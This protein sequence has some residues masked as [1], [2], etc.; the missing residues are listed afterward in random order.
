VNRFVPPEVL[1]E[2]T[3]AVGQLAVR[4]EEEAGSGWETWAVAAGLAVLAGEVARRQLRRRVLRR[5]PE[6]TLGGVDVLRG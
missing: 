2:A 4:V 6:W 3:R 5:T 1:A